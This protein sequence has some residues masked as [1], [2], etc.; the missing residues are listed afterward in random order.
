VSEIGFGAWAIGSAWGSVKDEDSLDAL[1]V[2]LDNGVDFLDTADV[3]GDDHKSERLIASIL[4]E[5]KKQGKSLPVVA[6]K[7]G[8]RLPKQ[9]ADLF[10]YAN[11][12]PF[13]EDSLRALEVDALDLVQL[14]CPETGLAAVE[15]IRPFVPR[16]AT[17]AQFALRWVLMNEAI[18]VVIPGAKNAEQ[19]R[20]NLGAAALAPLSP[21]TMNRI[22][23]IYETSIKPAVHQRW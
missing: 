3:Y 9:D 1:R 18:S 2:S 17:M 14:H 6:T 7:L 8:R 10:T 11:L 19:A 22:R 23:S 20:A 4:K 13:V 5:R 12:A 16:G 21:E 15:E